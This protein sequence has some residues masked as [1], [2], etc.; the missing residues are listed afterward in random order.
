MKMSATKPC[1]KCPWR[2][3]ITTAG[4]EIPGFSLDMMHN[5]TS[6]V[7][8]RS[9]VNQDGFYKIMAC[10]CSD[11]GAEYAC[12]GYMAAH[13]EQNINVR[14]LQARHDIDLNA[15]KKA[16]QK[17]DELYDNFYSML[18]DYVKANE[19]QKAE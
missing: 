14:L 15:I 6:T 9:D 3:S 7:P 16:C 12:A 5:L 4:A 2:K 18:D 11:I 10:H 1:S 13:G 17:E 19:T 8:P